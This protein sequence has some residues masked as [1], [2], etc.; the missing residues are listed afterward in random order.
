MVKNAWQTAKE[1]G[2]DYGRFVPGMER[3]ASWI[4]RS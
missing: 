1:K 4:S 3:L 2:P